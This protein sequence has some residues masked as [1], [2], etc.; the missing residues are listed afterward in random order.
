MISE[1]WQWKLMSML[2]TSKL[3][4]A[5]A[6][7]LRQLCYFKLRKLNIK[8]CRCE[9]RFN[10]TYCTYILCLNLFLGRPI[11]FAYRRLIWSAFFCR[12]FFPFSFGL[13]TWQIQVPGGHPST[14]RAP[15]WVGSSIWRVRAGGEWWVGANGAFVL[16]LEGPGHSPARSQW[17]WIT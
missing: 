2:N 11:G 17:R 9:Q 12:S 3:V 5:T 13:H 4:A 6:L 1:I 16:D 7:L 8:Y 15:L 14:E 10:P